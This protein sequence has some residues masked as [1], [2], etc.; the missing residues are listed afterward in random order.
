M[1]DEHYPNIN[2]FGTFYYR[3]HDVGFRHVLRKPPLF[4]IMNLHEGKCWCGKPKELFE[5]LQRKYCCYDHASWWFYHIR[6]YWNSFRLEIIR[7]DNYTCTECEF[8]STSPE[9]F[10]VDHIL[11]ISLGGM[12]YDIDNVRT[13]CKSCHHKK[14]A[15]DMKHLK[16]ERRQL[17]A[18]EVFS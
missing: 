11:A 15:L 1:I 10:D 8:H 14:T 4:M 2:E 9:D 18:L 16:R 17:V 13:L 6:C 5:P 7:R 12:C 3:N